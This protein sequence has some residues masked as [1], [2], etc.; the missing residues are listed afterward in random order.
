MLNINSNE[1]FSVLGNTVKFERVQEDKYLGGILDKKSKQEVELSS[2]LRAANEKWK[3]MY[4]FGNTPDVE[5]GGNP[6]L[7]GC[8]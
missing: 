6:G 1:D 8:Y 2:R 3:K 5:Y 4:I 7:S